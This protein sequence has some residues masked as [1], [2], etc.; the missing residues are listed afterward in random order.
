MIGGIAMTDKEVKEIL[1]EK[2]REIYDNRD[3]VLGVLSNASHPDDRRTILEYIE[4]GEEITTENLIMLS[5]ELDDIREKR[6]TAKQ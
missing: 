1:R 5:V 2:L 3:F 4:K 6:E